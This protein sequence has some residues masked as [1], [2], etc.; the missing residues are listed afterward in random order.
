MPL[1]IG[2]I[3]VRGLL[4]LKHKPHPV[5]PPSASPVVQVPLKPI[6]LLL[7]ADAS[8]GFPVASSAYQLDYIFKYI[9]QVGQHHYHLLLL[10]TMYLL[11]VNV[12]LSHHH[13]FSY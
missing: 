9:P 1:I 2:H 3:I 6:S 11:M 10:L 7:K 8:V 4:N 5:V 13:A 12:S